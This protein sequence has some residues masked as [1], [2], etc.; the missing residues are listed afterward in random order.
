MQKLLLM[1]EQPI[2]PLPSQAQAAKPA[3]TS[4]PK[5]PRNRRPP[6][7]RKPRNQR[8]P[9]SRPQPSSASREAWDGHKLS[10]AELRQM[11]A[12]ERNTVSMGPAGA[13]FT[14]MYCNPFQSGQEGT[15]L[16]RVPDGTKDK[17]TV[18]MA[19]GTYSLSGSVATQGWIYLHGLAGSANTNDQSLS[20]THTFT[21]GTSSVTDPTSIATVAIEVH[22]RISDSLN[23]FN[24][25]VCEFRMLGAGLRV[26]A[27][28]VD[29]ESGWFQGGNLATGTR[30][31]SSTYDYNSKLLPHLDPEKFNIKE[32][33]TVRRNPPN[34]KTD[35]DDYAALDAYCYTYPNGFGAM[36]L[37]MFAGLSATTTLTIDWVYYVQVR[38]LTATPI[39]LEMPEFEPEL[40]HIYHLINTM[41]IVT[42][43]RTFPSF[44]RGV[45]KAIQ[46]TGKYLWNRGLKKVTDNALDAAVHK[47][48]AGLA[49]VDLL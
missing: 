2:P 6:Q 24:A 28:G 18:M 4:L 7:K 31:T 27:S 1:A 40:E 12:F 39:P 33:I 16:A 43:G 30:P 42:K 44:L 22:D 45:W 32:G 49:A 34:F 29:T 8:R 37:V 20:I 41:P 47:I 23:I 38:F 36:P 11:I 21:G 35:M 9:Q 3:I 13:T 26:N 10:M 19:T 25:G 17:C 46:S 48:D 5:R 15:H 14:N